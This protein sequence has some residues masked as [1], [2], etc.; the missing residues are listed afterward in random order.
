MALVVNHGRGVGGMVVV[1][2]ASGGSVMG[3]R[4]TSAVEE[5]SATGA[6]GRG[7]SD[8]GTAAKHCDGLWS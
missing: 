8:T 2:P 5:T 6:G 1:M 3:A 7:G 4:G